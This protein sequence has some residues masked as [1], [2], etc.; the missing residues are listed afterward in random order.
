MPF[1][2]A[3]LTQRSLAS[4]ALELDCRQDQCCLS[5]RSVGSY[6]ARTGRYAARGDGSRGR[7]L[8]DFAVGH[9]HLYAVDLQRADSSSKGLIDRHTLASYEISVSNRLSQI[10][11]ERLI[12]GVAG[13]IQ[14]SISR[15][16]EVQIGIECRELN[17]ELVT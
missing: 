17:R 1:S 15:A 7:R 2:E 13:A 16:A 11:V 4:P 10:D 12:D 6:V 5:S 8:A 3:R 9:S 14:E